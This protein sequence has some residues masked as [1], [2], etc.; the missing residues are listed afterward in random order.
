M[1]FLK[2]FY[3]VAV[4]FGILLVLL[5]PVTR[6]IPNSALK[7]DYYRL[8]AITL[9]GAFLGAK[10]SVLIGDY[11]W[12]WRRLDD[13]TLLLYSGRSI[14]GALIGGFLFAELAKPLLSYSQPP[15]DRFAAILPFSIAIGRI[16]CALSGCCA[17]IPYNGFCAITDLRGSTR[18]PAQLFEALF[19]VLTGALFLFMCKRRIC[20][21]RLFSLYLML[22]GLF[23]FSS[24]QIR[25]TPKDFG[26]FSAYQLLSIV[27]FFLGLA[28]FLRRTLKRPMAWDQLPSPV[29]Q[30][31]YA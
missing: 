5:F 8:Q 21:G 23:R 25:E 2:P 30:H 1:T 16:G 6:Q 10:F 4:T 29:T 26:G 31:T 19:Q 3:V 18:F 27:M 13:W 11:H 12:P 7:R 17:G 20:F 24:E 14:T 15:N 22:Y 9:L 28:F